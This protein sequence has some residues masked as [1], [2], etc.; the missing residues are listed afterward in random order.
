MANTDYMEIE[1]DACAWLED[2]DEPICV[3][4]ATKNG[5]PLDLSTGEVKKIINMLQ[6]LVNKVEARDNNQ[7]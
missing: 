6:T 4:I 5:D 2:E 3:K 1:P 7:S